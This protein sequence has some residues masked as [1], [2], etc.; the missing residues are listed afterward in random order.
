MVFFVNDARFRIDQ[1]LKTRGLI[2]NALVVREYAIVTSP[3]DAWVSFGARIL[4]AVSRHQ[5]LACPFMCR[6]AAAAA[7]ARHNVITAAFR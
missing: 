6:Q 4:R 7:E 1:M 2:G 3:A 5:S